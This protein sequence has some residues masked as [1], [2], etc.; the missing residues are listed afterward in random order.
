[1]LR[2]G[3]NLGWVLLFSI[4]IILYLITKLDYVT[5]LHV[6][7]SHSVNKDV[8]H[9]LTKAVYT[10]I[11]HKAQILYFIFG[12]LGF[13]YL[14][15]KDKILEI[16]SLIYQES[17]IFIKDVINLKLLQRSNT[18][19]L[20]ITA[21]AAFSRLYYAN[22]P[23]KG[24]E[25]LV[26]YSFVKHPFYITI[27]N[28]TN[29]GNHIFHSFITNIFVTLF[30]D[31]KMIFRLPVIISGIAI[32]PIGYYITEK[33]FN[34]RVGYVFAI[35]LATS[36][37][38]IEYSVNARGYNIQIFLHFILIV[39]SIYL[40]NKNNM[41][42]WGAWSII[43]ALLFWTLPTALYIHGGICLW[44][45]FSS[46]GS[47]VK[48][49][50]GY[51]VLSAVL[52]IIL[53]SPALIACGFG[54]MSSMTD[55]MTA[56]PVDLFNK[57]LE[58][59][60]EWFNLFRDPLVIVLI[61]ISVFGVLQQLKYNNKIN[62]LLCCYLWVAILALVLPN[63]YINLNSRLWLALSVFFYLNVALGIEWLLTNLKDYISDEKS[64]RIIMIL[65]AG[66]FYA[67]FS[68]KYT[69]NIKA[70]SFQDAVQVAEYIK[71]IIKPGD[72]I[73][74]HSFSL[75]YELEKKNINTEVIK[76]NT[77]KPYH[78]YAMQMGRTSELFGKNVIFW[79]LN[80]KKNIPDLIMETGMSENIINL[81]KIKSFAETDIY[82]AKIIR[83][84]V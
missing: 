58:L 80:W 31:S 19:L 38:L 21:L 63:K 66:L 32:V 45:I 4:S 6:A 26:L 2:I 5:L 52:T 27:A 44:F 53:Y 46:K 9:Y 11:L 72:I 81:E 49:V 30:G 8:S 50:V 83:D 14:S 48:H 68:E 74:T 61:V 1:M 69:A 23:L 33:L 62:L 39:L 54:H 41:F 20:S 40:L 47:N 7:S 84:L 64:I 59:P 82:T 29:V 13:I 37:A 67:E 73:L 25:A 3:Y 35:I 36:P 71:R 77:G 42:A 56:T 79:N 75:Q 12:I 34:R 16:Y 76:I 10:S 15:L 18:L 28:Y 43:S 24:D 65:A 55:A 60:F 51:S 78:V 17:I 57:M 22:I 70:D